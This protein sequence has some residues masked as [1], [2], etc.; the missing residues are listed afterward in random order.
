MYTP[1]L[2][3]VRAGF[4][5]A[6]LDSAVVN[7]FAKFF[8]RPSK[9]LALTPDQFVWSERIFR[10]VFFSQLAEGARQVQEVQEI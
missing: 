6:Y 3:V 2:N 4:K 9:V 5:L 8:D 10:L 1:V 7:P